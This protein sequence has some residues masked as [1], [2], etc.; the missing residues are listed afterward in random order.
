MKP[1]LQAEGRGSAHCQQYGAGV[2]Q[3][4]ERQAD[5]RADRQRQAAQLHVARLGEADCV[6]VLWGR[7]STAAVSHKHIE[8]EESWNAA[9]RKLK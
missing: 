8:T 9:G 2:C 6:Q 7:E 3:R 1:N 4:A 5:L